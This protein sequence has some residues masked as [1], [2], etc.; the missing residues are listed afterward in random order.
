MSMRKVEEIKDGKVQEENLN[1]FVT[2]PA[3]R[4][5]PGNL[6][7]RLTTGGSL[8]SN[9]L[10]MVEEET[11]ES[12]SKLKRD[13]KRIVKF[14]QDFRNQ[15]NR[16]KSIQEKSDESMDLIIDSFPFCNKSF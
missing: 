5:I 9:N 14:S 15:S 10:M 7:H 3:P 1:D 11:I 16:K 8:I 2:I 4:D 12:P 6:S 13:T